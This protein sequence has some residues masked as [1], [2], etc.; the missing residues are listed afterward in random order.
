MSD[1][2]QKSGERRVEKLDAPDAPKEALVKTL[3]ENSASK[4]LGKKLIAEIDDTG[5]E[6][7]AGSDETLISE[8]PV[9]L[10]TPLAPQSSNDVS[11]NLKPDPA[12]SDE[13]PSMLEMMMEAQ[14]AAKAEKVSHQEQEKKKVAKSGF[15]GFKKGF[16]GDGSSVKKSTCSKTSTTEPS[17]SSKSKSDIVEVRKPP[18]TAPATKKSNENRDQLVEEVQR[19]MEK[20]QNPLLKQLQSNE[21]VTGD[22]MSAMSNNPILSQGLKNPRCLAAMELLQRDPKEAQKRFQGDPEVGIFMQE[23]CKVMSI[24]FTAL[25]EQQNQSGKSSNS[26]A[27]Q[28]S[29]NRIEEIGPLQARAVTKQKEASVAS[30]SSS[31]SVSTVS[32]STSSKAAA[33]AS[34]ESEDERVQRVG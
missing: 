33:A 24:H 21:W 1:F 20:D 2:T 22:L 11:S 30:A 14:R 29:F 12:P 25:G 8:P 17:S 3:L 32:T 18:P 28:A 16:F 26:G 27:P 15:G 7:T 19:A 6:V 13:G 10:L 9:S 31:Q 23:F 5:N 4:S 34:T